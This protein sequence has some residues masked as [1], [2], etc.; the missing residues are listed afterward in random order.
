MSK[1]SPLVLHKEEDMDNTKRAYY[2]SLKTKCLRKLAVDILSKGKE[3][4]PLLL[5]E[6]TRR[7]YDKV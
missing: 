5:E 3:A 6:I 1:D 7:N 2:K 4:D